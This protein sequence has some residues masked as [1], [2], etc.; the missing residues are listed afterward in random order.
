[1]GPRGSDGG[2]PE[3]E[4]ES[5]DAAVVLAR[6]AGK[7]GVLGRCLYYQAASLYQKGDVDGTDAIVAELLEPLVE[8]SDDLEVIALAH[9]VAGTIAIMR[10]RFELSET[11]LR[12]GL[13]AA[14]NFGAPSL[15]GG[16]L[17]SMNVPV[18][19]RGDFA[20]AAALLEE[21]TRTFEVLGRNTLA[22]NIRSNLAA[23]YLAWGNVAV[24]REHVEI[25]LRM[26][27]DSAT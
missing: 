25:A 22:T 16:M 9:N 27:R 23:V 13:A 6:E 10:S 2:Q 21:A 19:Y 14:R 12:L 24:A 3:S 4:E 7:P 15:I 20:H 26:A 11:H 1:M 8:R 17:C 18:Y 5:C